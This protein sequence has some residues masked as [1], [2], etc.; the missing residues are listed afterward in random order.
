MWKVILKTEMFKTE[1]E[2]QARYWFNKYKK[3]G[4]DLELV[5]INGD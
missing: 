1:S 5:E 2:K 3:N 4:L